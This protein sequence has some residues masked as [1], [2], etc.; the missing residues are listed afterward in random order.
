M[1]ATYLKNDLQLCG[2]EPSVN[3]TIPLPFTF[4]V[5]VPTF[6]EMCCCHQ[7]QNYFIFPKSQ[8]SDSFAIHCILFSYFTQYP[9]GFGIGV[10]KSN[11]PK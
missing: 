8:T 10:V 3:I 9:N 6:F 1:A 2:W 4:I 11:S 7:I 5:T